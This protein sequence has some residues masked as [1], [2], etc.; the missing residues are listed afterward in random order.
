MVIISATATLAIIPFGDVTENGVVLYGILLGIA[1]ALG[2]GL[3]KR[4]F[5]PP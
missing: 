5:P 1:L 4:E 3:P 2:R